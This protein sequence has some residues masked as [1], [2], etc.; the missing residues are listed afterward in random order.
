MNKITFVTGLWDIKRGQLNEG[1]S[2]SF[3]HYLNKL[4]ELLQIDCNLII[5]GE[6]EIR[7]FVEQKRDSSNTQFILRSKEWFQQTVPFNKIQELRTNPNW[8]REG[9]ENPADHVALDVPLLIRLLE[10]AREDAGTDMDLH[11]VAERL[12]TMS[13]EGRTL[14]MNDYDSIVGADVEVEEDIAPAVPTAGGPAG[15]TQPKPGQP[16]QPQDPAQL[17]A[18]AHLVAMHYMS[19]AALVVTADLTSMV[20]GT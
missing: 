18:Q 14:S 11:R 8:F 13:N 3:D 16:G 15:A 19:Q 1:W 12:I 17:A 7:D 9:D 6:E 2:R 4:S 10:Y 20:T 5:F